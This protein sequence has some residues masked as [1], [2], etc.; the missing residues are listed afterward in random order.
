MLKIQCHHSALIALLQRQLTHL[1]RPPPNLRPQV[2]V[3]RYQN[4]VHRGTVIPKEALGVWQVLSYWPAKGKH[5]YAWNVLLKSKTE[6]LD[7]GMIGT[8]PCAMEAMCQTCGSAWMF[9]HR[10]KFM[11]KGWQRFWKHGLKNARKITFACNDLRSA[12]HEQ[13]CE[14]MILA[15]ANCDMN[16][17]RRRKRK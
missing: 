5:T 13:R 9:M 11:M 15:K 8:P 2:M 12:L 16:Y 4:A 3:L 14:K 6:I 17:E 10:R 1:M 7:V